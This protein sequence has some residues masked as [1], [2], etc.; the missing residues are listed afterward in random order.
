MTR[1]MVAGPAG[2]QG[3]RLGNDVRTGGSYFF[4]VLAVLAGVTALRIADPFFLQAVRLIAFDS[5]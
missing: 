3:K 4:L 2:R 5:Y 1:F